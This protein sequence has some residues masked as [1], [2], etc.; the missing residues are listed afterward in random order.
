MGSSADGI[1]YCAC[2]NRHWG[3]AGAAGILAWRDADDPEVIM[4]LR[5]GW[6]MSGG[7]W[8][9][10]GGAIDYGESP[11]EGGMREAREEA[12]LGPSRVWAA[13]T[14]HHPDWS[15]TTGVAEA[16]KGQR[17]IATDHESDAMEWVR[18]RDLEDRV[19]MPAFHQSMP[20]LEPLLG[21]SLL[22]IDSDLLAGVG[23]GAVAELG[24]SGIPSTILP[25]AVQEPIIDGLAAARD[26]DFRRTV[27]LFPDIVIR[28]HAPAIEPATHVGAIP[29]S[30]DQADSQTANSAAYTRVFT[31][32]ATVDGSDPI[33]PGAFF[34]AL[35]N[36]RRSRS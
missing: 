25:G 28:G 27:A 18:W 36:A 13:T 1:V 3:H 2:G 7:T 22:V 20:L 9:I 19:L 33:D 11:I 23:H 16:S 32:G 21:R 29:V 30:I 4:Q 26:G 10:P 6:S 35:E 31:V 15:Y 5:A 17:A 14:L 34:S 24:Y 12:G 8:G